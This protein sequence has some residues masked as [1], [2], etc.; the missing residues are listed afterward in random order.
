[1]SLYSLPSI[2]AAVAP[3]TTTSAFRGIH[4]LG[5]P[6]NAASRAGNTDPSRLVR[7]VTCSAAT[8]RRRA[9]NRSHPNRSPNAC[10]GEV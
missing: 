3:S 5:T 7:A 2:D 6:V 10:T 8:V 1:M 4:G 9:S